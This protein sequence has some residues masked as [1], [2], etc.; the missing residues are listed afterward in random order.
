MKTV[1]PKSKHKILHHKNMNQL[2]L[3]KQQNTTFIPYR[4]Q[5]NNEQTK[6]ILRL[7]KI[8]GFKFS[9]FRQMTHILC[10]E[11]FVKKGLY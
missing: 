1:W 4:R 2:Q 7:L 5:T 9:V 6:G 10:L 11:N 3:Q 8:Q